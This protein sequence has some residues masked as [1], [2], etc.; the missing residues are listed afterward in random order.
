MRIAG[1][2]VGEAPAS[3]SSPSSR[4]CAAVIW[5][6]GHSSAVSSPLLIRSSDSEVAARPCCIRARS[7]PSTWYQVVPRA[8]IG[9]ANSSS[10]SSTWPAPSS[11]DHTHGFHQPVVSERNSRRWSSSHSGCMIEVSVSPATISPCPA[12]P[13]ISGATCSS[14]PSH[15]ICGCSQLI[16]ARCDPSGLS[17][18][19]ATNRADGVM[20]RSA[21]GSSAAEPSSGTATTYRSMCGAPSAPGRGPSSPP[22]WSSQIHHTSVVPP[23]RV[24]TVGS[25]QRRDGPCADSTSGPTGVSGRGDSPSRK[26][27]T[28]WS[29]KFTK[30]ISGSASGAV[31][32][33]AGACG[34]TVQ[35]APPYSCTR[36]RAL[37][38]AGSTVTGWTG[39]AGPVGAGAAAPSAAA[40]GP[41]AAGPTA[42]GSAT[43]P[44]VRTI[45]WRP[46]S[47]A[48]PSVHHTASP[49]GRGPPSCVPP[50]ASSSA[51]RGEGQD[52]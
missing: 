33:A 47:V 14:V 34:T 1:N 9:P 30:T 28:R 12:L 8:H 46:P 29:S 15:G 37:N 16:H 41:S 44:G 24:T 13:P 48:I 35:L 4:R 21:A 36:E 45:A 26:A 18:G 40:P 11:A 7:G 38:G 43:G 3:T 25:A 19:W 39:A 20:R 49:T 10:R 17:R 50:V 23:G 2:C 6:S 22:V 27:W 5:V 32:G 51:V 42:D 52:P 31:P